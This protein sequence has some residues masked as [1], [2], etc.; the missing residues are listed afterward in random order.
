MSFFFISIEN[1]FQK[2]EEEKSIEIRE[3]VYIHLSK[4]IKQQ[5][6]VDIFHITADTVVVFFGS[7]C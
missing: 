5:Q 3:I 2:K 1:C 7:N 6:H 4:K